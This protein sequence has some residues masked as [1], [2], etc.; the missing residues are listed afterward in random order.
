MQSSRTEQEIK[1]AIHGY[2]ELLDAQENGEPIIK[3][4]IYKRLAE[5]YPARYAGAFERKFQNISA[6]LF[7]EKLP[8]ADGLLGYY[9][10]LL[11]L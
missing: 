11:K 5:K 1:G 7:E 8:F 3:A 6:V 2:F 10:N 9:Q 4:H